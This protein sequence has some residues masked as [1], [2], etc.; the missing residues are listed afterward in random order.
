MVQR[1]FSQ[2][3]VI[4]VLSPFYLALFPC[5]G[6]Y[7]QHWLNQAITH[8]REVRQVCDDPDLRECLAYTIGRYSKVGRFNVQVQWCVQI[9]PCISYLGYNAPWAPGLTLDRRVLE[10]PIEKGAMLLVHESLHDEFPFFGH[11]HITPRMERLARVQAD[12]RQLP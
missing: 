3:A 2:V 6:A 4:W 5:G 11:H 7:E 8:L 12:M 9:V 10:M 1:A